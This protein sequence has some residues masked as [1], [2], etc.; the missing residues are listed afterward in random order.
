MRSAIVFLAL[1]AGLL[2]AEHRTAADYWS[3]QLQRV[4][5][6]IGY[7]LH[8]DGSDFKEVSDNSDLPDDVFAVTRAHS[9]AVLGLPDA[10][11]I[12][13]GAN[14]TALVGAFRVLATPRLS[15]ALDDGAL[16]FD[17]RSAAGAGT[18]RF[19]TKN[20]LA[21]VRGAAGVIG[22]ANDVTM[23]GCLDCSPGSVTV[24][25]ANQTFAPVSGQYVAVSADGGV[26]TGALTH[27]ILDTFATVGI[28]LKR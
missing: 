7:Q 13:F 1:L 11:L 3:K 5:G 18:Y 24:Q 25:A 10:S 22:A 17:V 2:I 21:D 27:E 15:V 14:T 28:P 19:A 9:Q 8:A 26:A 4:Q 20:L 23:L 6:T 16:R 12:S